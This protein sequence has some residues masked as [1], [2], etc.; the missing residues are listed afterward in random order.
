MA[1]AKKTQRL[2]SSVLDSGSAEGD[3]P[4]VD[5]R[6]DD[7]SLNWESADET[8][9]ETVTDSESGT[10][11][12]SAKKQGPDNDIDIL[13]F[14]LKEVA[15]RKLLSAPEEKTLAI[16]AKKNEEKARSA[17]IEANLRLVISIA[18]KYT[19]RGIPI[20]D[21]IQEGNK[22][23]MR[24]IEKYDPE[25]GFRFTT[26]ACWWIKQAIVRAIANQSRN[27]RIPVHMSETISRVNR[28]VRA[29]AANLGR[30]PT[31]HEIAAE[32]SLPVK[33]VQHALSL[34]KDTISLEYRRFEDEE[35][36]NLEEFV[37]GGA[38]PRP[39][40]VIKGKLL[41][42]QVEKVLGTLN[43]KEQMV[44]RYRFGIN[45]DKEATLEQIG[46]KFGVSRERIRQ[47]EAKALSLLRH[48]KRSR[49]LKDFYLE[50]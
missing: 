48:P 42:E 27:I 12:A 36:S 9:K 19:N 10:D 33:K 8:K 11:D 29:L 44:I 40:D 13:N 6:E 3:S 2:F 18:K 16:R 21:L 24:A 7:D 46:R 22:G 39:E 30:N 35:I 47:I 41:K 20:L 4:D 32:T 34:N 38:M 25:R 49:K 26:Y 37:E 43:F 15:S 28:A 31:S 5:F 17:L 23:L 45:G 1:K 50:A 14:Y